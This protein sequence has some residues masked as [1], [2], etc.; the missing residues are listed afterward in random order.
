ML[1]NVLFSDVGDITRIFGWGDA[2]FTNLYR[3]M[4]HED[5][6]KYSSVLFSIA[7][8]TMLAFS[9]LMLKESIERLKS[10]KGAE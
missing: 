10:T 7:N 5:K 4:P 3:T 6:V 1:F 2:H 8:S 9:L